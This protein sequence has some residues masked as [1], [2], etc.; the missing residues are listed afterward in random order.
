[1]RVTN[2][3]GALGKDPTD[4]G[5]HTH[6][7]R[8]EQNSCKGGRARAHTH[9]IQDD[10]LAVLLGLGK[11]SQISENTRQQPIPPLTRLLV[12]VAIQLVTGNG[13]SGREK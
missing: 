2:H 6:E 9:T 10:P 7:D 1:M 4:T 12:D 5:T 8:S 3:L 13:L 11:L